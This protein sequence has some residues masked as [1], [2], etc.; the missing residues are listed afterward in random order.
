MRRTVTAVASW[1]FALLTPDVM[2]AQLGT[3]SIAVQRGAVMA[4]IARA[5]FGFAATP[6]VVID[7]DVVDERGV[8]VGTPVAV[9]DTTQNRILVGEIRARS[10]R[11]SEVVTCANGR[12]AFRSGN[13]LISLS[14]PR[15]DG[16]EAFVTTT[17]VTTAPDTGKLY[18]ETVR[19][20]LGRSGTG[21]RIVT[22]QRLGIS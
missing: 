5:P 21:W 11:R 19:W 3:D 2:R 20:T 10:L 18:F 7:P 4:A 14:Q 6:V 15:F 9:R 22:S 12:C 13:V 1:T 16:A 8:P 17:L